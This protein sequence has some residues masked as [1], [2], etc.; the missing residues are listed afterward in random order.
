MTAR[1]LTR[2]ARAAYRY[3][4]IREYATS[5]QK[6]VFSD[7]TGQASVSQHDPLVYRAA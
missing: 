4:K 1:D 3:P 7:A 5:H 6:F 2:M